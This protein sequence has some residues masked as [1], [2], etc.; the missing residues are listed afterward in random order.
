MAGEF[1][2]P[3]DANFIDC[4]T[5]GQVPEGAYLGCGDC[6]A[7]II[8]SDVTCVGCGKIIDQEK[9]A[10]LWAEGEAAEQD[11]INS[12]QSCLA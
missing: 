1:R 7:F 12:Q 2:G 3:A 9:N 4:E 5:G 8:P 10:S 11:F 6:G